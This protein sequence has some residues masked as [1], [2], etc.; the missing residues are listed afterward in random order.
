MRKFFYS[1]SVFLFLCLLSLGYYQSY[2]N[3]EQQ[4]IKLGL[5]RT[6][7]ADND[8]ETKSPKEQ[9]PALETGTSGTDK[10]AYGVYCLKAE[11]GI[12]MVYEEDGVTLYEPTGIRLSFLPKALQQE[13]LEGKYL[14]TQEEL[15]SFLENYSS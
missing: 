9:D 11:E 10:G 2:K 13:I 6:E 7:A 14:K 12:V 15:Y 8:G 4:K 1:I 5:V 3:V